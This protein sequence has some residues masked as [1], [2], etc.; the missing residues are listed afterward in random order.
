MKHP[1]VLTKN[2]SSQATRTFRGSLFATQESP[3]PAST[4]LLQ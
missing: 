4:L 3:E 1:E 2:I